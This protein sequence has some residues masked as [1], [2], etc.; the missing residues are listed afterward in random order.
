M[1][2]FILNKKRYIPITI[3]AI[4][5]SLGL[6]STVKTTA[7][8][9]PQKL[10]VFLPAKGG[11]ITWEGSQY[12]AQ[13]MYYGD[14]YSGDIRLYEYD[15]TRPLETLYLP[16]LSEF[17]PGGLEPLEP[18]YKYVW[19]LANKASDDAQ[20]Y[21]FDMGTSLAEVFQNEDMVSFAARAIH[22]NIETAPIE[23]V[24]S[25][26]GNG[27]TSGT[28]ADSSHIYNEEK[29]LNTNTFERTGYTFLGWSTDSEAVSASYSN[30]CSVSNLTTEDDKIINLYAIWK[31]N[32]YTVSFSGN[33]GTS[34]TATKT[35]T[36]NDTYGT[37]PTPTRTGYTF[38]GWFTANSGG[39]QITENTSVSTAQNHTLYAHW[40]ANPYKVTYH[41]NGGTTSASSITCYYGDSVSLSPTASKD[42]YTFVGWAASPT[43]SVPLT[44]FYMPDLA[45]S[46][47]PDY[48]TNWELTLYALYSI[49]VSD[50]SNH[51]YPSYQKT[52]DKEVFLMVW[53][54]S[55]PA[56]YQTYKLTYTKDAGIMHYEYQLGTTDFSA[57]VGNEAY[58]YKV[59]AYDNAGNYSIL[60]Q[61][62]STGGNIPEPSIPEL[63]LQT[64]D[65]YTYDSAIGKWSYFDSISQLVEKGQVFT[66]SYTTPPAGYKT[67]HI[68]PAYKVTGKKTTNAYY[69]PNTYTLTFHPNGGTVSPSSKKISYMDYYGELPVPTKTGHSF[70][71]WY[72]DKNLKEKITDSMQYTT[73]SDSTIYAGW[74]INSYNVRYDYWT[75][76]GTSTTKTSDSITYGNKVD[77]SVRSSKDGWSFIGW[78]TNP[79][80]TTALSSLQMPDNDLILYA[81]YKKDISATFMD[82]INTP[83]RTIDKTIYNRETSCS[84]SIPALQTITGWNS[85]GW[86]LSPEPDGDIHTSPETTYELK[87]NTTFYGCYSQDI[88]IS[89]DSNGSAM[90]LPS[91][92]QERFYNASGKYKNPVFTIADAPKLEKHAFVQWEELDSK[93]NILSTYSSGQ[94]ISPK[95]NL[96]L[97]AKWD[98]HPTLEAYDR[99]FTLEAAVSGAITAEKLLEKVTATDKEDGTL[100]NGTAVTIPNLN[101]YDFINNTDVTITYQAKDSFGTIIEKDVVIHIT[102]TTVEQSPVRY[103]TRFIHEDFYKDEDSFIDETYGGLKEN[104]IWRTSELH[105]KLLEQTLHTDEPVQS[106]HFSKSEIE[107]L[108][109]NL[110]D[111]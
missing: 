100:Q 107:T 26:Q 22:A 50:V 12:W 85:C 93:G 33:G 111:N 18:G 61:G 84:I 25:Y 103:F 60:Y 20:G 80:A 74:Q 29:A 9:L 36:Y 62:S 110:S 59:L 14:R 57:Y 47:N 4:L 108:K 68:D 53:K 82:G 46:S 30:G 43:A 88:T 78:N 83:A 45:T 28:M 19:F 11:Y 77:V 105:Q 86:S 104:S 102:D 10:S 27:A 70:I 49:D 1:K 23:Y 37:L 5:L 76:G 34:P 7:A 98:A 38:Q 66:P 87:E 79:N 3:C 31:A 58:G 39:T 69:V 54:K 81:I 41:P 71:G 95:K 55:A 48:S 92:T 72:R 65:H 89:Y 35:V 64:V 94:T 42:G 73:T 67:D 2:H 109:N 15:L 32:D 56:S 17:G 63:Y 44:S 51:T 16:P 99:Y 91:Q 106:Y 21:P 52:K 8:S 97:S 90:E 75:N 13:S 40:T 6:F 96:H 24:I 101:K